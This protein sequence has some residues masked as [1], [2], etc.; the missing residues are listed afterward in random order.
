MGKYT[1]GYMAR[2]YRL[3]DK[4]PKKWVSAS[5]DVATLFLVSGVAGRCP[6]CA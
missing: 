5:K 1:L 3:L 4:L 2:V 6:G